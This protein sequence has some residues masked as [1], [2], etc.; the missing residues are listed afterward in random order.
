MI[1]RTDEGKVHTLPWLSTVCNPIIQLREKSVESPLNRK[2]KFYY[3]G[4]P[5]FPDTSR[6]PEFLIL[7]Y[8]KKLKKCFYPPPSP[9]TVLCGFS[10]RVDGHDH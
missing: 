3:V 1:L 6:T 8:I 7:T 2:A 10:Y 5:T 4:T 9:K